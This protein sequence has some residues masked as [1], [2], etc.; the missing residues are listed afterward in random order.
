MIIFV[1]SKFD[2]ALK[3]SAHLKL[4]KKPLVASFVFQKEFFLMREPLKLLDLFFMG[5][6]LGHFFF[7]VTVV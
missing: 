2:S 4:V 7:G 5:R 3:F 6:V 1:H